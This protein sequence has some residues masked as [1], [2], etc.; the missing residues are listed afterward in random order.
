MFA[1]LADVGGALAITSSFRQRIHD[2][3]C[4]LK[5]NTVDST[6]IYMSP[7][8]QCL[9]SNV[10]ASL[11]NDR[12]SADRESS[13]YIDYSHSDSKRIILMKETT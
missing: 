4:V 6:A 3:N 10:W 13:T 5:L 7:A 2:V 12:F 1:E 9:I 11:Q 8:E